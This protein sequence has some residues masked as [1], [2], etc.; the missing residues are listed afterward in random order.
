V[1]M[2]SFKYSYYFPDLCIVVFQH[3]VSRFIFCFCGGE[4]VLFLEDVYESSAR[5]QK[6]RQT[7]VIFLRYLLVE[8]LTFFENNPDE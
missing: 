2:G 1:G 5:I 7:T 6:S 8:I 3:I 4:D